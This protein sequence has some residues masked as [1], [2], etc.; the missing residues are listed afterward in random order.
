MLP[1]SFIVT[2][3]RSFSKLLATPAP[4]ERR[5]VRTTVMVSVVAGWLAGTT[6]AGQLINPQALALKEFADRVRDYLALQ[7]KIEASLQP[8]STDSPAQFDVHQK[9][10][11]AAIRLARQKARPGDIFGAAGT[12]F[13]QIIRQ[14][15]RERS[16][17]DIVATMQQVPRQ[18]APRVNL[19]Y[20]ETAALA[21]VPPLILNRLP[22]LPEGIEFRF[23][24]RDLILRD[25]NANLIV[26]LLHEAV[27][28]IRR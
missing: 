27:P 11:A 21:T 10:L 22:P 7:K 28:T 13:R 2:G 26:D 25:T 3:L 19:A 24:G 14:D 5:L 6:D 15:A 16:A 1:L 4:L 20:P 17:R 18:P 9:A 8:A 12:Q 23:M